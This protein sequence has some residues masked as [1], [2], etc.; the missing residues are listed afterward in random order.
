[1]SLKM[2]INMYNSTKGC[3]SHG[4]HSKILKSVACS[5]K[6]TGSAGQQEVEPWSI[7][8]YGSITLL[9]VVIIPRSR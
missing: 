7:A 1:M 9:Q 2:Y 3:P 6:L 8:K 4:S 5:H